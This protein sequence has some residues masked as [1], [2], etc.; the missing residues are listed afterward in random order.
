MVV[1]IAIGT[2]HLTP[3]IHFT[4]AADPPKLSSSLAKNLYRQA[5]FYF[6]E[7][8]D[9]KAKRACNEM[10]SWAEANNEPGIADEMRDMLSQIEARQK[11]AP[12]SAPAVRKTTNRIANNQPFCGYGSPEEI[13]HTVVNKIVTRAPNEFISCTT[14]TDCIDV[15]GYCGV[16]RVIN[17]QS[18]MCFEAAVEIFNSNADCIDMT[19]PVMGTPVCREG[20]CHRHF[21][22]Q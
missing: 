5:Q 7:G 4:E 2:G 1:T 21:T 15:E 10:L 12:T 8:M 3:A 9:A 11:P 18:K 14:D 13:P 20:I 22:F 16:S 19:A 6:E 17:K